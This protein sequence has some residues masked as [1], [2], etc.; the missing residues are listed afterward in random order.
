[1]KLNF[2][3]LKIYILSDFETIR[4]YAYFNVIILFDDNVLLRIPTR[5]FF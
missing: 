5:L 2:L 3:E 4:I 1:M